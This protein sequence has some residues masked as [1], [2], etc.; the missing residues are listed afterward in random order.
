[1]IFSFPFLSVLE[2]FSN[3]VAQ[4]WVALL[5]FL[6]LLSSVLLLLYACDALAQFLARKIH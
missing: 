5:L 6:V 1:M 2:L 3:F 4:L